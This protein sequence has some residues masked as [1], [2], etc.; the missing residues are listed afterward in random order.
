M[1]GINNNNKNH[2]NRLCVFIL[3]QNNKK[4]KRKCLKYIENLAGKLFGNYSDLFFFDDTYDAEPNS[5]SLPINQRA[6]HNVIMGPTSNPN[7][8][9]LKA[10]C[11]LKLSI[12]VESG[13][14][15]VRIKY[16]RKIELFGR[17]Q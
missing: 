9:P 12:D 15:I 14:E 11:C 16:C 8:D 1:I 2:I 13:M 5:S 10:D 4:Y 6:I 17:I 3:I 7:D